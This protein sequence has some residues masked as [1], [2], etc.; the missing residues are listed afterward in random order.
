[1]RRPAAAAIVTAA[2]AL[3]GAGCYGNTQA[4]T[5]VG[6]HSAQLN[7]QGKADK[8]PAYSY[9]EY[10][11]AADPSNKL[12]TARRNWPAGAEGSF[13]ER[14]Q[15]L[16]GQTD[17]KY[18]LC[19]NDEGK[20]PICASTKQFRTGTA[21]SHVNW[22]GSG[23]G[24][25]EFQDDP[26]VNSVMSAAF[27]C[28]EG[29]GSLLI[30]DTASQ[31][32]GNCPELTST[33]QIVYCGGSTTLLEIKLAD[34]D[35]TASVDFPLLT[36]DGGSGDDSLVVCQG[37]G[38]LG[39][40]N[41]EPMITGGRGRDTITAGP[42]NDTINARSASSLDPDTDK[43]ISCGAGEDTVIAD[44]SDP[45]SAGQNGCEHVSKP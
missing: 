10:W 42:G 2:L 21:Y 16:A 14:P 22:T 3:V 7:A 32:V 20:D 18:R 41:A 38:V 35:D 5:N 12:T 6:A 33:P 36:I 28:F 13:F 40:A 37:N 29:C 44:R 1:M 8:G 11:K 43:S 24:R 25:I 23:A 19:G 39:C 26:G 27:Y 4:P 31:I 9:F 34:L 30:R 45:I 17:Y 15:H